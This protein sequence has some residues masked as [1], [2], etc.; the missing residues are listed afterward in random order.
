MEIRGVLGAQCGGLVAA[1]GVWCVG[2]PDVVLHDFGAEELAFGFWGR[3]DVGTCC[4]VEGEGHG[5]GVCCPAPG[6]F[7]GVASRE[8][9]GGTPEE[10]EVECAGGEC[11]Y[12]VAAAVFCECF[13][14]FCEVLGI[15]SLG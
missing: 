8:F 13:C 11:V 2:G 14:D 6:W 4:G 15:V 9:G 10:A 5:A 12:E 7:G 3:V 1:D